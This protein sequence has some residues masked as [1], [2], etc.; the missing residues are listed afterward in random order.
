M[1]LSFSERGIDMGL[2]ILASS[3]DSGRKRF[4]G[5]S[6]LQLAWKE[7]K[8]IKLSRVRFLLV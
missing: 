4:K 2:K 3:L 5:G 8:K 6:P 1:S 7:G